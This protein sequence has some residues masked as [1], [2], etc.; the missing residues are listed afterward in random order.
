MFVVEPLLRR[1]QVDHLI[2]LCTQKTPASLQMAQQR[3]GLVLGNHA[4]TADA[5]VDAIGEREIDDA[6]LAAKVH[7][8]LGPA[9]GQLLEARA[10]S[11]GEHQGDGSAHQHMGL[12]MAVLLSRASC[13]VVHGCLLADGVGGSGVVMAGVRRIGPRSGHHTGRVR[14]GPVSHA[15]HL[16][17]QCRQI[18]KRL[19]RGNIMTRRVRFMALKVDTQGGA[20]G[21]RTGKPEDH[22]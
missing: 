20:L 18:A 16:F 17:S 22:A 7:G 3:M 13:G 9:V 15:G 11:T 1:Q 4:D 10:A 12:G 14:A 6:E 2:E 8:G 5:A 21:A 19:L